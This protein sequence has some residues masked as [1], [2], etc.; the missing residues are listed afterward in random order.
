MNEENEGISW[1]SEG[2]LEMQWLGASGEVKM[3][4]KTSK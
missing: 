2:E 3:G 4:K 1:S